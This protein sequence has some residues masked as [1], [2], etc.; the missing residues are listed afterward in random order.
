MIDLKDKIRE[1]IKVETE[2][3]NFS[4]L[5]ESSVEL[6]QKIMNGYEI[7][8]DLHQNMN[9]L[10]KEGE[11]VF[12][13]APTGAGKD[14][15]VIK[16]N[17][18]NPEKKYIELNVDIFRHYFPKFIKNINDLRDKEFAIQTNE[19]AYEIYY[20]V[21]ELLLTEF[22]GTNIIITGTIRDYKW[23]ELIFKKYKSN[24]KTKY[25][26]RL[27]SLG[28]P[29]LESALSVIKRYVAIV[30]GQRKTD[31]FISGSAR[32]TSIDYHDETYSK[33]PS[34]FE[35]FENNYREKPG[36]LIDCIEVYKR[37][38]HVFDYFENNM[39]YSTNR[40]DNKN[41]TALDAVLDLRNSN[42]E[43][44]EKDKEI[45]TSAVKANEIYLKSQDTYNELLV[46][47]KKIF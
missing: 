43:I 24:L 10:P 16:L 40:N 1:I 38:K 2:K 41:N 26:V 27:V 20:T 31:N 9:N 44:P 30:D 37:A 8:N 11:L 3:K 22:P 46:D 34:S 29:K 35:Y 25:Y 36:E 19:F 33:F 17:V 23:A 28:V 12:I 21:Q 4:V 42:Y 18:D 45:I 5:D 13:A 32:Y 6:I 7:T 14:S 15:L 47:L 39:V